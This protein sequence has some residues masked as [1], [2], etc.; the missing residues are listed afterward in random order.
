L[1]DYLHSFFFGKI[2]EAQ[3]KDKQQKILF[4]SYY[5]EAEYMVATPKVTGV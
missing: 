3:V 5:L 2:Q 4:F 1:V